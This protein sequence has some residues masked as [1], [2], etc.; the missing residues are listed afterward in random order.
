MTTNNIDIKPVLP[1][2]NNSI[3][4]IPI[5][6]TLTHNEQQLKYQNERLKAALAQSGANAKNWEIELATLK[7]NNI[8][9][10]SALQES[11]ANVDEWKRQLHTYKEDN[12]RL[13]RE[14]E[15]VK[16]S[17]GS[18]VA[19]ESN[20][21]N[22]ELR[23]EIIIL[24]TRIQSLEKDLMNQEIELKAAN[25]SLKDRS[26]D[27]SVSFSLLLKCIPDPHYAM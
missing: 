3:I 20:D 6:G 7:S 25:N 22:E 1:I 8:R 5:V 14:L 4:E 12:I 23:R 15:M 27:H 17:S 13:K 26:N 16:V 24:K 11:T 10:T 19:T 2:L 9:L 18:A 21:Q